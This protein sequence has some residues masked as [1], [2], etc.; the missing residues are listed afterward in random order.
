[1]DDTSPEY[2]TRDDVE[3][4]AENGRAA[5]YIERILTIESEYFDRIFAAMLFLFFGVL[6]AM[7]PQYGPDSRLFPLVIGIPSFLLFGVLLLIQ[8]SS[9]FAELVGQFAT[10]DLF[11][12]EEQFAEDKER[13]TKDTEDSLLARRKRLVK[14]TL[15]MVA[16][17]ALVLLVGFLPAT[18]V[19]LLGF[20][21][22]YADCGWRRSIGY[23]IVFTVLVIVIFNVVM[24]TQF[25]QGVL[26]I[27]VPI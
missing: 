26:D 25:Y 7:T 27:E 1:M 9:R 17:F 3:R 21:R 2:T 20:Y 24:G 8:F 13:E 6:L 23:T 19:F 12:F 14:I 15:W 10:S 11:A 16:L 18:V 4:R 22:L 5:G